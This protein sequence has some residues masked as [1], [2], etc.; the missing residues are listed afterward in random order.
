[1]VTDASGQAITATCTIEECPPIIVNATCTPESAPGANDGTASSNASGGCPP[2]SY[3]WNTGDTSPDIA[4]LSPGWY[5]VTVTDAHGCTMVDSC[6]VLSG[7]CPPLTV[8]MVCDTICP[9]ANNGTAIAMVSGGCPPYSFSW[10]HGGATGN[11]A[12]GLSAGQV[13]VTVTDSDGSSV[14]ACC[15]IIEMDDQAPVIS[16]PPDEMV[17]LPPGSSQVF[18]Q[19]DSAEA[20]DNCPPVTIVNDYNTGGSDASDVYSVGTTFVEFTAIDPS[21][22]ASTCITVVEVSSTPLHTISGDI[23]TEFGT[24]VNAVLME[25]TD[26]AGNPVLTDTSNTA[27]EYSFSVPAGYSIVVTPCKDSNWLDGVSTLSLILIQRHIL[28]IDTLSPYGIIA[29]DANWDDVVSTFDLVLLQSSILGAISFPSKSWRFVYA[30][31][32]FQDP[33]NPLD[34]NF[35]EAR[36]YPNVTQDY[37]N[38]DWVGIKIGDVVGMTSGLR[39]PGGEFVLLSE[40]VA[41]DDGSADVIFRSKHQHYI[42]GYQFEFDLDLFQTSPAEIIWDHSIL[43]AIDHNNFFFD[44]EK[45]VLRA[46]WWYSEDVEFERGVELFRIRMEFGESRIDWPGALQ[47]LKEGSMWKS[48]VYAGNGTHILQPRLVWAMEETEE[49]YALYQNRPN[50]FTRETVIPFKLPENMEVTLELSD[51]EGSLLK[52][53]KIDGEKGVNE[54]V[55]RDQNLPSG[56]IFYR[57]IAEDWSASRK[58]IQVR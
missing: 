32:V 41:N 36:V 37:S 51:V 9:G 54:W 18:V 46:N 3:V 40:V 2:L 57:I 24:P 33:L 7:A 39:Y 31:Y 44:E 34:E 30:D 56:V 38:E 20:V 10:S 49:R 6:E 19:L 8:T 13:C 35:T 23:A 21:G 53:L 12:T 17:N 26:A 58:M 4:G 15:D 11:T 14:T 47:L 22:N 1:V 43:P 45:G 50:P 28:Q 27:G 52:S 16:C 5:V 55:L 29:A 25:V 42:T 48:E